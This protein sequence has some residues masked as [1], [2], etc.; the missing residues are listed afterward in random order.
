MTTNPLFAVGATVYRKDW[1]ATK[2]AKVHKTGRIVLEGS[3]Q[4]YNVEGNEAI[5]TM[6]NDRSMWARSSHRV[7]ADIP[8]NR[9]KHEDAIR[10][11]D[12]LNVIEKERDRLLKIKLGKTEFIHSESASIQARSVQS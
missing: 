11:K 5:S 2:V 7:Y 3:P 12:A 1:T 6:S 8:E 4:Q 9:L 10:L